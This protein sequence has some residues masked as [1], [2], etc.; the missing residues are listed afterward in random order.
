V[1]I[2]NVATSQYSQEVQ[3]HGQLPTEGG[4]YAAHQR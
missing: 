1:A 3:H 2:A 4:L